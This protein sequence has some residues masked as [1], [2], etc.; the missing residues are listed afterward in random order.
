[1]A[2]R[3]VHILSGLYYVPVMYSECYITDDY[4]EKLNKD[5]FIYFFLVKQISFNAKTDVT[6]SKTVVTLG[7]TDIKLP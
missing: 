1:M 7:T 4:Q 5:N 6:I 2:G 3:A